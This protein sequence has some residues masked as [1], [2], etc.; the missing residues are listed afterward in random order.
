MIIAF[1]LVATKTWH[2]IGEVGFTSPIIF[3]PRDDWT[4]MGKLE[5]RYQEDLINK[6]ETMFPESYIYP[7]DGRRIQGF[8]DITILHGSGLWATL[9]CKK[10]KH[11]PYRPNQEYYIDDLNSKGFS[12][13]ICPENEEE[14]LN[15]LQRSLKPKRSSRV[16]KSK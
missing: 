8:P 12:A 16:S 4:V 10:S 3:V 6:L 11:E 7:N 9:E 5:N 2:I 14:V 1:I 13:M 15:E